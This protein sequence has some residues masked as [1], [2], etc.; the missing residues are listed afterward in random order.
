VKL[1][2]QIEYDGIV[3][4][5]YGG[6]G[7]VGG[8]CV[9]VVDGD[10]KLVFDYGIRYNAMRKFYG[11]RI[12][13]LGPAEMVKLGVAHDPAIVEGASALYVS[14]LHLDH[15]G[16]LSTVYTST[17]IVFPDKEVA[18]NTIGTWYERSPRWLSY[19]PPRFWDSTASAKLMAEDENLVIT[20]PVSHSAYP[21]VAYLYIGRSATV[22]Y[23]GDLRLQ[24]LVELH[25]PLRENLEK[26]GVE[27]VDVAI[28]E[29]MNIG[30][31]APS[32][33][34]A[35]FEDIVK[36]FL[37]VFSGVIVSIDPHDFEALLYIYSVADEVNKSIVV[38]SQ[39]IL[40]MLKLV[41]RVSPRYLDR[42][43]V[44]IEL[45][46]P[47][48]TPVDIV[49]LVNDVFRDPEGYIVI[50]EPVHLLELLRK[51]KTQSKEVDLSNTIALLLDPEPR[52]AIKEVENRVLIQWLK[53]FGV[54]PQRVRLSGHYQPHQFKQII[55]LLKPKTL[56]PIHTEEPELML[57]LFEKYR[58]ELR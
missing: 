39:R 32:V 17:K 23:S 49:S 50:A 21:S 25:L 35:G 47:S 48:P 13:P 42:T 33:T 10:K 14:H 34:K 3:I 36:S 31:P 15:V 22:F 8:N 1:Q 55:E 19:V 41:S 29:G 52:E 44:A 26:L 46:K 51:L 45:E 28:I 37:N 30:N 54:H 6:F 57:K 24:P 12:E 11:G 20:I 38:A 5:V 40:W 2:K 4:E 27:A 53:M 9:A 18:K 7:E 43:S 16:L 56:I 58:K